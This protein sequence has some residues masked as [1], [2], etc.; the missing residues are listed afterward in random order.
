MKHSLTHDR[1]QGFGEEPFYQFYQSTGRLPRSGDLRQYSG[2]RSANPSRA[3]SQ[4][5]T[6]YDS[7]LVASPEAAASIASMSAP[8]SFT[9]NCGNTLLIQR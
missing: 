6:A 9:S 4:G 1:F 8:I 2:I 3:S 7:Q 5:I